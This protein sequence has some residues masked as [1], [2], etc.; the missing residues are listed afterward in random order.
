M[1]L[2]R[3]GK[4]RH[5]ISPALVVRVSSLHPV[6]IVIRQTI[7]IL[8]APDQAAIFLTHLKVDSWPSAIPP[9]RINP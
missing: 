9:H 6:Q 8:P 5:S 4:I 1:V 7:A 3:S 2:S